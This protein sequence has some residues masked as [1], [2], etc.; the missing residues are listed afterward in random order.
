M[1]HFIYKLVITENASGGAGC[2]R[3][4]RPAVLVRLF[5]TEAWATRNKPETKLKLT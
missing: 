2:G 3:G 1:G 5:A 4:H